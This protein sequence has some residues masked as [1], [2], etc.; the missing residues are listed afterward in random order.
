MAE[1]LIPEHAEAVIKR[2]PGDSD[3]SLWVCFV[4]TGNTCRSPMA[5]AVANALSA[6]TAKQAAAMLPESVRDCVHL[7]IEAVSAGLYPNIG[8]KIADNAVL[9]LE[10][11]G[12]EAVPQRDFHKHTAQ[13]LTAELAEHCDLLIGMS[14]SHVIE[15]LMHFPQAAQKIICMPKEISDPYGGDSARYRACLQEIISGVRELLFGENH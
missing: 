6:E 15:M 9:A 2:S 13:P 5:E 10:Q 3:A 11:A 7:P 1:L 14:G 12:I 8:E 4:C